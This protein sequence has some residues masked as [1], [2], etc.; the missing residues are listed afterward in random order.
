MKNHI[1]KFLSLLVLLSPSTAFG[2]N[3]SNK[4]F[5]PPRAYF[6]HANLNKNGFVSAI[7][8]Q[9]NFLSLYFAA[10]DNS[11][12]KYEAEGFSFSV[13]L[14]PF[15]RMLEAGG[16]ADDVRKTEFNGRPYIEVRRDLDPKTVFARCLRGPWGIDQTLWFRLDDAR[17][18]EAPQ[19][20][21]IALFYRGKQVHHSDARLRV[22]GALKT[23]PP[24]DPKNFKLWLHYGPHARHPHYDELADYLRKA[25]VNTVQ[26]MSNPE[27]M[28][29]MQK[30]GFFVIAQRGGSYSKVHRE[31]RECLTLG[32]KWFEKSDGGVMRKALP[33]GDAVLWD[34]E[35]S[36]AHIELDEWTA[37]EFAKKLNLDKPALLTEDLIREKYLP[38]WIEFRQ[39]QCA[40]AVRHW[41][42]FCRSFRPDIRTILTEGRANVFDPPG[43]IDYRNVGSSVTYCD[44]MNFT[45][46]RAL[47][48]LKQ[49]MKHAPNATF[50]GCQNVAAG[51]KHNVFISAQTIMLQILGSV[52]VGGKGTSIYPGPAMDGENFVL[53]NR[54]MGFIG[55]NQQALFRGKAQPPEL[56]VLPLPK[57]DLEVKLGDGP[58]L[59]NI[60]PDWDR[61]SIHRS[62][63]NPVKREYLA[64]VGNWNGSEPCIFK[65]KMSTGRG[66]WRVL[67]DENREVHQLDGKGTLS[68]ADLSEGIYLKVPAYDYRGFR[69]A[70]AENVSPKVIADY[71][72]VELSELRKEAMSYTRKSRFDA[73][74]PAADKV[75]LGFDDFDSNNQ[76][77]YVVQSPKQKLWISQQGTILKWQA[78]GKRLQT[79]GQGLLRDM[80]WL[81]QTERSNASMDSAMTL[82][83]RK[84][85]QDRVE[86][87]FKQTVSLDTVGAMVSLGIEKEM[88][89][90]PNEGKV[91]VHMRIVNTSLAMELK[92][93][94]LSLRV[95]NHIDHEKTG[96]TFTWIEDSDRRLKWDGHRNYSAPLEGLNKEE[97][98]EVFGGY[99]V[100]GPFGLKSFGEYFPK[101]KLLLTYR[102]GRSEDLLQLLR[103]RAQAGAQGRGGSGTIEWMYQPK[104]MAKGEAIE[105]EYEVSLK[106]SDE[107]SAADW[108]ADGTKAKRVEVPIATESEPKPKP[109]KPNPPKAA[110][111][112]PRKDGLLFHL[113]FEEGPDAVYAAGD[114]KASVKGKPAYEKT[115]GGRG[116]RITKGSELSYLPEANIN[117]SRG[118]LY[119]KF[120]PLWHGMDQKNHYLLTVTPRPG[121]LY[122]GKLPD[123]R[124]ILNM[125]DEKM[126]QHYPWHLIRTMK[127]ETWHTVTVTW[128]CPKGRMTLFLDGKK[129][130]GFDGVEPWKMGKLDN[131]NTRCRL[132]ITEGADAVIEEVKIWDRPE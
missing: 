4:R 19:P 65:L 26:I 36:P 87:S 88:T 109:V 2:E 94:A 40:Q 112:E 82:E 16:K 116:I 98:G 105:F 72:S 119:M 130:A 35:P 85:R 80:I 5:D 49:W 103:W 124:L 100:M 78:A 114:T 58:T 77:E 66:R 3:V 99:A 55:R 12:K 38:R 110:R 68:S 29:E 37:S 96:P 44:P 63:F 23:P 86:L 30:R 74:A 24:V 53:F 97:S 129:V 69:I 107:P 67:D 43:Q 91:Q 59:R 7:K 34:F 64:V 120:K 104:P 71:R 9:E 83:S 125:F 111:P 47:F 27:Y 108:A 56:I 128:D 1:W 28:R 39:Q 13:L 20:I 121:Y 101:Q 8:G 21:R 50:T 22:Y 92:Q 15:V 131:R 127:A 6:T 70:P 17:V 31:L 102:P 118:K 106:I 132:L 123:G 90:F 84:V 18:P 11:A 52:L 62:F 57:E 51:S 113:D 48:N 41:A 122:F 76:L 45:G 89:V 93:L 115:P 25:G 42:D 117:L 32:P 75:Q 54:V 10:I 81:P 95:H 79:A 61:E 126:K 46:I 33:H 60:Y 14:P 73:Q